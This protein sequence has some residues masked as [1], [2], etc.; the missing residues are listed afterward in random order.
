MH[1]S[2]ITYIRNHS[3]TP[4]TENEIEVIKAAFIPKKLRK[5]QYFLQ[6]GQV[7]KYAGFIVKG[8]M[9]QYTVNDKGLSIL[10]GSVLKIGGY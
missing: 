2:L 9:R 4:L 10:V 8:A 3:T 6:E 5:R 7:C 1:E